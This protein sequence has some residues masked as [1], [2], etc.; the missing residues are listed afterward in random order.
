MLDFLHICRPHPE[1]WQPT[2]AHIP[3]SHTQTHTL[4]HDANNFPFL[5]SIYG[6]FLEAFFFFF[7]LSRARVIKKKKK[8][9]ELKHSTASLFLNQQEHLHASN[10]STRGSNGS[11]EWR[12]QKSLRNI[13]LVLSSFHHRGST[14]SSLRSRSLP[15]FSSKLISQLFDRR[16]TRLDRRRGL[17]TSAAAVCPNSTLQIQAIEKKNPSH[18]FIPVA[19]SISAL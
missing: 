17:V 5:Y 3:R 15:L 4:F 14:V 1:P 7:P 6:S 12:T 18:P 13:A 10:H 11:S 16:E 19:A 8:S 9:V 2:Q